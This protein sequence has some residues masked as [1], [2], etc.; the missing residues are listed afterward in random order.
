MS[1]NFKKNLTIKINYANTTF[2]AI[3]LFRGNGFLF[4]FMDKQNNMKELQIS[5]KDFL[6]LAEKHRQKKSHNNVIQ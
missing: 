6:E 5:V 2:V 1:T 4:V 3:I